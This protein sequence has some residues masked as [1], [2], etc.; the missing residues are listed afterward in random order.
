LDA[1]HPEELDSYFGEAKEILRKIGFR[2]LNILIS[3]GWQE[4]GF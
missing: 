3:K 2:K 1:H 4:V